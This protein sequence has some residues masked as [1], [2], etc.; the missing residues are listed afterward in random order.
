MFDHLAVLGNTQGGT[1]TRG[2]N[3]ANGSGTCYHM[4]IEKSLKARPIHT[5]IEVHGG[6]QGDN[7]AGN[8][9]KPP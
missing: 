4:Q 5:A 8:H 2:A 1:L 6:N 7:T 3:S 9:V